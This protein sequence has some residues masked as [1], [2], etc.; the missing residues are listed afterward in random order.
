VIHSCIRQSLVRRCRGA[1]ERSSLGVF[2][3]GHLKPAPAK[4][5]NNE[6][7]KADVIL[8]DHLLVREFD[9]RAFANIY[10][11]ST[12]L[13]QLLVLARFQVTVFLAIMLDSTA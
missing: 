6:D 12:P 2:G 1:L 8:A 4:R 9:K 5:N 11:Y 3:L 13:I 7:P 10:S